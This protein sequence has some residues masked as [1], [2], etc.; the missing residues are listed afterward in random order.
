MFAIGDQQFTPIMPTMTGVRL[1]ADIEIWG[2]MRRGAE[3]R[4]SVPL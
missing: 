4:V 3:T 1:S 2:S